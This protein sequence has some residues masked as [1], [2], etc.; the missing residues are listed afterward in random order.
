VEADL[1]QPDGSRLACRHWVTL[2]CDERDDEPD[3]VRRTG[4]QHLADDLLEYDFGER[5]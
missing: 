4:L 2:P 5:A 1:L 3:G